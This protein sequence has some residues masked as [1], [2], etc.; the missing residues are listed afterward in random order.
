MKLL[1]VNDE[2]LTTDTLKEKIPWEQYGINE[3]FIAYDAQH[4][5]KIIKN[6]SIDIMLCDIE[7]PVENGLSLLRWVRENGY[8]LACVFLTC[9]SEFAYAQEAIILGCENYIVL[10]TS[11]EIIGQTVAD[12]VN[13]L[14][15]NREKGLYAEYGKLMI[16]K[17]EEIKSQED[18][19]K[20]ALTKK[21]ITERVVGAIG[22]NLSNEEL[23]VEM[24]GNTLNF[25]PV[26]L[27]RIFKEEKGMPISQYIIAERMC[28]ASSL[29]RIS[30]HSNV[31]IAEIVG[32]KNYTSFYNMFLRYFGVSPTE[33]RKKTEM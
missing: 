31:E 8:D 33:Y 22:R 17:Q 30:S 25:H 6:E 13:H 32:Y 20:G 10:P 11:Y 21:E 18:E 1:I 9:Y 24:L 27:N 28:L 19:K 26:Y 29:L 5:R 2:K 23:S 7:M 3:V 12:T 15:K 16:K 14:Q 4:S